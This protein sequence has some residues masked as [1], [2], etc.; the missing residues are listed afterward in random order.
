[1]LFSNFESD[2][3]IQYQKTKDNISMQKN[4]ICKVKSYELVIHYVNQTQ[5]VNSKLLQHSVDHVCH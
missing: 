4:T 2:M 3:H 5:L 1:M